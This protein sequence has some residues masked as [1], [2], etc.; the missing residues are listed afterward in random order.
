MACAGFVR[1]GR[2]RVHYGRQDCAQRP[3]GKSDCPCRRH[4]LSLNKVF[5]EHPPEVK[6][7]SRNSDQFQGVCVEPV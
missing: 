3:F 5:P 1:A 7:R 2:T 4:R 6:E